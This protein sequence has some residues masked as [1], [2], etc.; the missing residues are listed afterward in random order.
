VLIYQT[1]NAEKVAQVGEWYLFQASFLQINELSE[2]SYQLSLQFNN[3]DNNDNVW[4]DDFSYRPLNSAVGCYVYDTDNKLLAEFGD[5][6][7]ATVYQYDSENN[8]M[9]K[10][11]ETEKGLKTLMEQHV[12]VIKTDR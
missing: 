4:L 10:C 1:V 12:N 5:Q 7:F 2:G 3:L 6:H 11:V 9:R 8:L